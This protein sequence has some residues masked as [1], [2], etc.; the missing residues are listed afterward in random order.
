LLAL[1]C[2]SAACGS[3]DGNDVLATPDA[4]AL[5]TAPRIDVHIRDLVIH[6]EP[7]R[8]AQERAHGL[9][10]IGG[11]PN[12]GGM[13]FFLSE[14]STPSFTMNEMQFP[15]DFIWISSDLRVVDVTAE[16]PHPALIG[17]TLRDIKPRVPALYVLEVLSRTAELNGIEVGDAVVFEPQT[18]P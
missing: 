10:G 16:V 3:G 13:L 9:S 11:I 1:T 17:E 4:T 14:E 15:L 12:D 8:T 2:A 18:G 7:A 6:A 5:T